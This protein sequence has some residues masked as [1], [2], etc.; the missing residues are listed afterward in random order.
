MK[1]WNEVDF[2]GLL[3][4]CGKRTTHCNHVVAAF[5]IE[6]STIYYPDDYG[7]TPEDKALRGTPKF[8]FMYVWQLA[9]NNI[10]CY[11]RTWD[12]F[13]EC[14]LNLRAD[15]QLSIDHR[16]I[17]YVH[18][19]K[20]EFAFM[21][22]LP[23]I[24]F[25]D[26]TRYPRDFLA[27]D[28]HTIIKCVVNDVFEFRDSAV[29]TECPLDVVGNMV[30]I[31]KLDLDYAPIRTSKTPL[32][33][34]ELLYCEHDVLILSKYFEAQSYIYDHA[35]NIPLTRSRCVK[36]IID[37]YQRTNMWRGVVAK[38][39]NEHDPEILDRL[40]K[41]YLP[42]FIYTT[43]LNTDKVINDVWDCDKKSAYPAWMLT[44]KYPF[45][46]FLKQN[47]DDLNAL[48]DDKKIPALIEKY[49][50]RPLLVKLAF[51]DLKSVYPRVGFLP[52]TDQKVK[53]SRRSK[54]NAAEETR[55]Q[56][57]R[58]IYTKH[59]ICTL[60]DLDIELVQ[61]LYTYKSVQILEVYAAKRYQWLPG[62]I[63]RTIV[64]LYLQKEDFKSEMQKFKNSLSEVQKNRRLTSEEETAL[65][66]VEA[67]Y[68]RIK[69]LVDRVYGIFVQ[70]PIK[71]KWTLDHR[72]GLVTSKG[73]QYIKSDK[74]ISVCYEWGVWLLAWERQDMYK[75][76]TACNCGIT[77]GEAKNK[78]VVLYGDTDGYKFECKHTTVNTIIAEYNKK[79]KEEV[80]DFCE[81]NCSFADFSKLQNLGQFVYTHYKQFKVCKI[82]RYAYV[83]DDDNFRSVCS[84]LPTTNTFFKQFADNKDKFEY[85]T[86][87]LK[88]PAEFA[89]V[90]R[91]MYIYDH[92]D[93]L[94]TDY[95][96]GQD[97]VQVD[98]CI[99]IYDV[100]FN[101]AESDPEL[102]QDQVKEL[103]DRRPTSAY[104]EGVQNATKK[105]TGSRRR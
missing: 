36:R 96:G 33:E 104:K 82:K 47:E 22:K 97:R 43:S 93:E 60:T 55:L 89:N 13:Y 16:L 64:D 52:T 15:L 91:H 6:T 1:Y 105:S 101:M 2:T 92:F 76:F 68:Q 44:R 9:V 5:D 14:L 17:V 65:Y 75:I 95:L 100:G 46:K 94:V 23:G 27:R 45:G 42:P 56:D 57:K 53:L 83:D 102:D 90:K 40:Q 63:C 62:Y 88:I 35:G 8:A 59:Y 30:G 67:E 24:H 18:N 98:S 37:D 87:D 10:T 85:F 4:K 19:L 84:G 78:D 32:S 73:K 48:D 86:D 80:I 99:C 77:D 28:K 12:E 103:E 7:I 66:K 34:T 58:I 72:T 31:K 51:G 69:S 21:Q 41:A 74:D 26:L 38:D 11:G 54:E 50:N 49:R 25:S 3:D 61:Q 81:R 29:F 70:D 79:V 71:P 39:K 20:Y